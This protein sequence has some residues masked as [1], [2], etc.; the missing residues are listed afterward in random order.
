[1]AGSLLALDPNLQNQLKIINTQPFPQD[2]NKN[3][4]IGK[5]VL[6]SHGNETGAVAIVKAVG[7]EFIV[8]K[9]QAIQQA[10]AE[11]IANKGTGKP[12]S[13][14]VDHFNPHG[15]DF[16]AKSTPFTKDSVSKLVGQ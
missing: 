2:F 10:K 5:A 1:M 16:Y 4:L 12:E 13:R 8:T 6:Y 3:S 7:N 15:F 9:D 11:N 14:W